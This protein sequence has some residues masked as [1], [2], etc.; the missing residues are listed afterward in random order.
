MLRPDPGTA[1]I[2][3]AFGEEVK[4]R[5][6]D[7]AARRA[8][9]LQRMGL[10]WQKPW[11]FDVPQPQAD[12]TPPLDTLHWMLLVAEARHSG[13]YVPDERL[14]RF[15]SLSGIS[16]ALLARIQNERNLALVDIDDGI[17]D[18]LLVREYA[19]QS[20]GTVKVSSPEIRRLVRDSQERVKPSALVIPAS[21]LLDEE[22]TFSEQEI[23]AAFEK[24]KDVLPGESESGF[25]YKWPARVKVEYLVLNVRDVESVITVTD[26]EARDHWTLNKDRFHRPFVGP[27][28]QPA[29]SQGPVYEKFSE[30]RNDVIAAL[31]KKKARD[32]AEEVMRNFLAMELTYDWDFTK[33]GEDR[34]PEIPDVVKRDDYYEMMLNRYTNQEPKIAHLV[35]IKRTDLA[36]PDELRALPG[37]G[38][39]SFALRDGRQHQFVEL[40]QS[41][42]GLGVMPETGGSELRSLYLARYQTVD[43]VLRDPQGNCYGFRVIEVA[44]PVAPASVEEVRDRVIS[45]LRTAAAFKRAEELA[46]H[47]AEAARESGMEEALEADLELKEKLG[48]YARI[49][50]GS[51]TPRLWAP[52]FPASVLGYRDKSLIDSVFK[53]AKDFDADQPP[54]IAAMAAPSRQ[55]WLVVRIDD[56]TPVTEDV[57][58]NMRE[59][60]RAR[61][62]QQRIAQARVYWYDP[63]NIDK[64]TGWTVQRGES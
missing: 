11:I 57:Y 22:Q 19:A 24:Y 4:R 13:T 44:D 9:A 37:I 64:R 20:M 5:A 21:Q 27:T 32:R 17:G 7:T 18:L 43:R 8:D 38:R 28:T 56:V 55:T 36:T 50:A 54:P 15:K 61:L 12:R 16:P 40:T 31:K 53:L 58:E 48:S 62:L 14:E 42:Q 45:D 1:T 63:K 34:Y 25:G 47:F 35:K 30:A 51:P 26:R 2:G 60:M 59:S 39:S 23:Q 3:L 49:Q 52:G 41:V 6:L 29:E 10:P 33:R 46:K